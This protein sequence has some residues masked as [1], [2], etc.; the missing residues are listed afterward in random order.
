MAA[1]RALDRDPRHALRRRGRGHVA[2]RLERAA[3]RGATLR[4][5]LRGRGGGS[6]DRACLALR[7][8]A[9][10][11][12]RRPGAAGRARRTC[13]PR[14]CGGGSGCSRRVALRHAT[15]CVA[16]DAVQIAPAARGDARS[17]PCPREN[18]PGRLGG[19]DR[20]A[21]LPLRA[22]P[23]ARLSRRLPAPDGPAGG[24]RRRRRA[25]GTERYR[26]LAAFRRAL[27]DGYAAQRA[28]DRRR[29]DRVRPPARGLAC[30]RDRAAPRACGAS[31]SG[32]GRCACLGG[33]HVGTVRRRR[34]RPFFGAGRLRSRRARA[35]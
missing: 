15:R 20:S 34:H 10:A 13:R 17:A 31:R 19:G 21:R 33:A 9:R 14:A 12:A 30:H 35:R 29:G 16:V 8:F 23:L 22:R 1:A 3:G 28:C 26:A 24:R 25:L 32:G 7:R 5:E 27:R 11:R 4:R 18:E 6:P 2:R